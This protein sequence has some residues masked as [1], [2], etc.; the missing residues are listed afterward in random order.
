MRAADHAKPVINLTIVRFFSSGGIILAVNG[1]LDQLLFSS[2]LVL[3]LPSE[4]M[5]LS[6]YEFD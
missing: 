5:Y 3:L 4:N 2:A 6:H 1:S